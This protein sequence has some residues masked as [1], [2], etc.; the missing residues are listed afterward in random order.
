MTNKIGK[1]RGS[2]QFVTRMWRFR[3]GS[4]TY[5]KEGEYWSLGKVCHSATQAYPEKA[6]NLSIPIS[7][8]TF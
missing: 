6:E 2:N 5:V 4:E 8:G 1:T 3:D 7:G